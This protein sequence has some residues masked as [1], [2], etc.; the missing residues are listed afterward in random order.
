[1]ANGEVKE[2]LL[3]DGRVLCSRVSKLG[4]SAL[5]VATTFS[6]YFRFTPLVEISV[7]KLRKRLEEFEGWSS[8]GAALGST[9]GGDGVGLDWG[10]RRDGS[11]TERDRGS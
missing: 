1:M 8:W 3:E 11:L 4:L 7:V 6:R 10:E 2:V 9:Q 5:I